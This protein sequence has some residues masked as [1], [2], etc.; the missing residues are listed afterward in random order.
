[1]INTVEPPVSG[2]RLGEV[3]SLEVKNVA[4]VWSW[5][6]DQ[7]VRLR[8]VSVSGGSIVLQLWPLW[9]FKEH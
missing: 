5:E 7:G 1:M 9:G 3:R 4:F 6:H 8:E 2:A